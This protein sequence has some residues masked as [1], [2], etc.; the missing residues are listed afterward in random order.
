M[1]ITNNK[2]VARILRRQK[3]A[4]N[5]YDLTNSQLLCFL[6][7][8]FYHSFCA[9]QCLR[10]VSVFIYQFFFLRLFYCYRRTFELE[11][12]NE[13][14]GKKLDKLKTETK[15]LQSRISTLHLSVSVFS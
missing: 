4:M 1:N 6:K 11:N 3:V 8:W 14:D 15:N 13:L 9:K 2:L 5:M 10:F 7:I 12:Q